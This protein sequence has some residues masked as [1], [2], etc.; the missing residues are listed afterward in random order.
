MNETQQKKEMLQWH[1]AFFAG[2]QIELAADRENLIFENEHQLGTKPMGI[3]V[4]IIKKEKALPVKKNIGRIFRKYN[5]IEY[6]GPTDYLSID[7]FYKAYG[8]T[9][10]YKSDALTVDAIPI[11]ELTMT[12]VCTKYPGKLFRHLGQ[13]KRYSVRN[14]EDGIYYVEGN[15]I[16]IQIIVTS[17]L[18]EEENL[19]LRNLTNRIETSGSI[20]RLIEE[21]GHHKEDKLYQS[22]MNL[23]V[24]ANREKFQEVNQMCEA[25]MELMKDELDA[26]RQ[27]GLKQGH[28]L[29]LELGLEQGREQGLEQEIRTLIELCREFSLSRE[30]TADKIRTRYQVTAEKAEEYLQKNW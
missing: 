22:V 6:K 12:L 20:Q 25:L 3:D 8:Y 4:L 9:C 26:A 14:V 30:K 1:P 21:Y 24:T 18:S 23:I 11:E 28:E 5:V 15:H 19:W 27:L 13:K 2:I 7:D 29:G 10:F 17:K 16:P